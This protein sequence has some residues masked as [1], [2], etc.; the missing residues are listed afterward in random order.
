MAAYDLEEQEQLSAIKAWW[1]KNGNGVSWAAF[2]VAA[3]ILGWQA[4][5]W[6]EAREAASAGALYSAMVQA[7]DVKDNAKIRQIAGELIDKH[8]KSVNAELAAILAARAELNSGDTKSAMSKMEWAATK[9]SDE[10]VRD[11]ARLRLATMQLDEK[12][13]DAALKTLETAPAAAFMARFEDLRGDVLF[14]KGSL[15]EAKGAYKKA[16]EAVGKTQQAQG[17]P[18]KSTIETKLEALGGN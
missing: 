7:V 18:F 5:R 15:E 16:L 1:E 12:S 14:A 13:Y 2:A 6:Y 10:V 9:G 17:S 8:G 11:L 3:V 4:W